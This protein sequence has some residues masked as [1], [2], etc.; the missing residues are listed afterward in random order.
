MTG[1]SARPAQRTSI[2]L[3]GAAV[4]GYHLSSAVQEDSQ[5][6]AL[7]QAAA[8]FEPD[9]LI[10]VPGA[11]VGARYAG[12]A[13]AGAVVEPL[14]GYRAVLD[15][16]QRFSLG[17]VGYAAY[18]TAAQRG[19]NFSAVRAG[20]EGGADVRLTPRS[21]WLELH[22]NAGGA[23]T[24]L[25]A[26][27]SYCLDPAG[28]FG[29]DCPDEIDDRRLVHAEAGGFY[30]TAH[31]GVS[32]DFGRHLR[33]AFHGVRLG[34]NLGGGTMPSVVAGEQRSANWFGTAGLS[35]T[36]GLGAT[37]LAE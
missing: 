13:S 18:A 9:A 30:P 24:G 34:A 37:R 10:E 21:S 25:D 5:G 35:L 11:F 23:I 17:L 16:D 31:L 3:Q 29:V 6:T 2:E 7:Q 14:L 28:M 19:A 36:L 22:A 15:A 27:G 1:V 8:V 33:S 26:E 32:L 12:E 4:P 20:V